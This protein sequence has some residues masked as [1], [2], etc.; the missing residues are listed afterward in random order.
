MITGDEYRQSLRDGR[1]V[2]LEGHR[3]DDVTAHPL[4]S[5]SVEW[6]AS[7][8][9]RYAGEPNPMF[10]I[11]T[12]EDELREQIDFLLQA[13]RT[14]ATTAGCF[15]LTT[16]SPA[17]RAYADGLVRR[18]AR[19]AAAVDDTAKP[20]HVVSRA[21]RRHRDQRR[22]AARARRRSGPRARRGRAGALDRTTKDVPSRVRS[23]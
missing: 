2:W 13:D 16:L 15:A 5:K 10:R 14:A 4:L 18:D 21:R 19:V 11:P 8:Y 9:E 7:T 17:V 12:S 23:R 6:V 20:V 3:V 22:Q 1:A